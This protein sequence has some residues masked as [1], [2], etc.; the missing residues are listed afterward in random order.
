M[1]QVTIS[2]RQLTTRRTAPLQM[3]AKMAR[4]TLAA[5]ALIFTP[6]LSA[7][8]P[9]LTGVTTQEIADRMQ[10]QAG[11]PVVIAYA[12]NGQTGTSAGEF[13][14]RLGN[15]SDDAIDVLVVIVGNDGTPMELSID[16]GDN[17]PRLHGALAGSIPAGT[18]ARFKSVRTNQSLKTG[19][20]L[21]YS[22]D[23]EG[24]AA[25]ALVGSGSVANLRGFVPG[26]LEP[27]PAAAVHIRPTA[28]AKTMVTL[29]NPLGE[30][31]LV[32]L[33]LMSGAQTVCSGEI[34]LTPYQRLAIDPVERLRCS[35]FNEGLLVVRSSE[36]IA[37]FALATLRN[38]DLTPLQTFR[39]RSD[40]G[41]SI[42]FKA[43][44]FKA[45]TPC[46]ARLSPSGY[47]FGPEEAVEEFTF[48]AEECGGDAPKYWLLT[49]ASSS[50]ATFED[51]KG[52]K[53]TS[54]VV[55]GTEAEFKL[56]VRAATPKYRGG[57]RTF[58][59]LAY[60]YNGQ[61]KESAQFIRYTLKQRYNPK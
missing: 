6:G 48:N 10:E 59:M 50:G 46:I 35:A 58:Y 54:L 56:G 5:G 22:S 40:L 13:E 53:V 21:V 17:R 12:Q 2:E 41:R 30:D 42:P 43:P 45:K 18:M 24:L 44:A 32:D 51:E 23:P 8:A 31:Q 19:Y 52:R 15:I 14:I 7:Q 9:M 61:K 36:A 3:M 55:D 57:T 37:V 28:I 49:L 1:S 47:T 39:V 33:A 11:D 20:V 38:G 16:T 25:E 27:M 34:A 4:N 60:R 26:T 29:A